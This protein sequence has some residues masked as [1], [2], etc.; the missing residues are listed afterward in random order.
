MSLGLLTRYG[1]SK[2]TP[3]APDGLRTDFTEYTVGIAPSD[4]STT[5]GTGPTWTVENVA[6]APPGGRVLRGVLSASGIRG[7]VWN[8]VP[9]DTGYQADV[10]VLALIRQTGNAEVFS[11]VQL[12]QSGNLAYTAHTE[13]SAWRFRRTTGNGVSSFVAFSTA[14]DTFTVGDWYWMRF[15][16]IGS[17]LSAKAWADGDAEPGSFTRVATDANIAGAGGAG[18]LLRRSANT[19]TVECGYFAVAF[20]G[21]TAPGPV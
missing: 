17:E 16:A 14:F 10:E 5:H 4:W 6:G 20:G 13:T 19:V 2:A 1:L 11:G 8:A 15:R 12:R 3:P 18:I 7:L 21:E 9:L